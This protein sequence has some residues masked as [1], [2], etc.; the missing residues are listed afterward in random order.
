MLW[1]VIEREL[2]DRLTRQQPQG[3]E[4]ECAYS[5]PS[6]DQIQDTTEH[7]DEVWMDI[8]CPVR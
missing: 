5:A 8:F 7:L 3:Q 6:G 1:R 2:F 4:E